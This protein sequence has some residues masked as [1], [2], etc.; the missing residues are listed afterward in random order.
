MWVARSW[1]VRTAEPRAMGS[2]ARTTGTSGP[3]IPADAATS[4]TYACRTTPAT[5][6]HSA[7]PARYNRDD[8]DQRLRIR[9]PF[10]GRNLD[11][12][13][14]RRGTTELPRE[15]RNLWREATLVR[16]PELGQKS[17]RGTGAAQGPSDFEAGVG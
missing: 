5:R 1:A 17:H 6:A 3:A 13:R 16:V 2:A 11:E 14:R 9:S 7:D 10:R 4:V 12:E 15:V 8:L